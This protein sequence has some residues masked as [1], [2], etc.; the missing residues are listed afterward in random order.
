[1]KTSN[2]NLPLTSRILAALP[3][4]KTLWVGVWALLVVLRPLLFTYVVALAGYPAGL[5]FF[6]VRLR[7]HL[8]VAYMVVL[9]VWASE[10]LQQEVDAATPAIERLTGDAGIDR[11]RPIL[12]LG[13]VSGPVVLTLLLTVFLS[14]TLFERYGLAVAAALV[15]PYLII[16]LPLMTLFWGYLA[17]LVGLD[18]LG[19]RPLRLDRFPD[20]PSLGLRPVGA[21]ASTTLWIFAALTVPFLLVNI[22]SRLDLAVGLVFF[23][24]GIGLFFLSMARLHRQMAAAKQR[25]LASTR[26]LYAEAFAPVKASWSLQSLAERVPLLGAAKALED[27]ALAIQEWPFDERTNSR[28]VILISGVTVAA[29]SRFVLAALGL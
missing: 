3:G 20:D 15:A 27:R 25:Y 16:N 4:P 18:R 23:L 17:L 5:E 2:R 19:R 6:L 29:I 13:G 14:F 21:L 10:R 24:A 9:S 7:P 22:D 28:I 8:V 26:A 11:T 12:G 1:M